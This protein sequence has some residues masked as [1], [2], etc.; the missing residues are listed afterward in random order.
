MVVDTGAERRLMFSRDVLQSR[1]LLADPDALVSA[2]TRQMMSF[3]LFNPEPAH[4]LMIGLGGG[5][6]VKFCYRH[7]P[8][9]RITAVEVDARVIDLRR[10]F[11]IP[12]DDHRLRIVH[13]DGARFIATLDERVDVMLIDAF[14]PGG[15][16]ALLAAAD[17]FDDVVRRLTSDGVSIMNLHGKP[18]RFSAHVRQARA[19]FDDRVVL[20][21][22]A[23]HNNV[24]LCAFMA[25]LDLHAPEL[26]ARAKEFR[27]QLKLPFPVYLQA[28]RAGLS[29]E[30]LMRRKRR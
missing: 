20:A 27:S 16:S 24:L 12:E 7:L 28:M 23:D 9:A 29:P 4:I 26:D 5:S 3:L 11:H 10:A 6:L 13:G 1:M 8:S 14:D 2:Y 17:F 18:E 15:V 21:P 25:N 22:V 19:A 30:D